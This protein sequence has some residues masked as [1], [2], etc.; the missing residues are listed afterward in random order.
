M[1]L[2][3][4]YERPGDQLVSLIWKCGP[5]CYPPEVIHIIGAE[6]MI[7]TCKVRTAMWPIYGKGIDLLLRDALNQ[8]VKISEIDKIFGISNGNLLVNTVI[9]A[10]K[11][12]ICTE[13]KTRGPLSILQVKK[14]LFSQRKSEESWPL[15]A[16]DRNGFISKEIGKDCKCLFNFTYSSIVLTLCLYGILFHHI[17]PVC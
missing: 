2:S 17:M 1:Y 3:F 8:H 14:R 12:V 5:A 10:A 7:P 16:N 11:E 4:L 13:R 15:L 6:L 9:L